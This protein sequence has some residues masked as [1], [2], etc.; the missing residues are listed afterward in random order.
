MATQLTLYYTVCT[1]MLLAVAA[2]TLYWA[3]ERT[4]LQESEA[5]LT[6]KLQVLALIVQR[7]PLDTD[8][9][10][11]EV[12]D[13]AQI[14][15]QMCIRDSPERRRRSARAKSPEPKERAP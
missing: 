1:C 7:R 3:L 10:E 8:G 12:R 9:L 15:A 11:Q 13:E 14:S 4:L 2:A 6:H 5:F